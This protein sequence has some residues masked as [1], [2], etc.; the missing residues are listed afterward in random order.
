LAGQAGL[1]LKIGEQVEP[2]GYFLATIAT[3]TRG[4]YDAMQPTISRIHPNTIFTFAAVMVLDVIEDEDL[5]R[6]RG[7]DWVVDDDDK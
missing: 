5:E 1:A 4:Y 2:A 3:M 7:I 6:I